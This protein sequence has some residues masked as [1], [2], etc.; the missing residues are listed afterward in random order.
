MTVSDIALAANV[1]HRTV[2]RTASRLFPG[3][4]ANGHRT[5]FSK[6]EAVKL[7]GE[8]RKPGFVV[9]DQPGQ[10]GKVAGQNGKLPSGAQ[11]RVMLDA[12]KAKVISHGR[13]D[14]V[15]IF[16]MRRRKHYRKSQG[17]RQNYT[18]IEILGIAA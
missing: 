6:E 9:V 7:M 14:K 16:K 8:L 13:G 10:N 1:S 5:T 11:M 17:H 4:M 12:V 18:E 3:K 2:S 15:R